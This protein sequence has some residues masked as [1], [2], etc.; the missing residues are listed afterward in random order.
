MNGANGRGWTVFGGPRFA[1]TMPRLKSGLLLEDGSVRA[2]TVLGFFLN[3]VLALAYR[4]SF[5]ISVS[6][7]IVAYV[8]LPCHYSG[9]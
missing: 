6:I 5:D 3:V 4:R 8:I 7:S 2:S 1:A 9:L